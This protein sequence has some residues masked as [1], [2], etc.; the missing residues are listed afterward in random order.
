MAVSVKIPTP[1]RTMTSGKSEVAVEAGTVAEALN[2]LTAQFDGLKDRL[3]DE[4][5]EVRRFVNVYVNEDNIKDRDNLATPI[6]DGDTISILPS[7][8]G[9]S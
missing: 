1:L 8:A 9:G 7:I 6:K 2:Q 3:L 5:G 4:S